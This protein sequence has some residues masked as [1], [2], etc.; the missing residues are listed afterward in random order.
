MENIELTEQ[1]LDVKLRD[2]AFAKLEPIIA[3]IWESEK[4]VA[5]P[6]VVRGPEGYVTGVAYKPD[7]IAQMRIMDMSAAARVDVS[8]EACHKALETLIIKKHTDPR[9]LNYEDDP[10]YWKGA[11]YSLGQFCMMRVPEVK[12]N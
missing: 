9:I 10:T 2:E 1:E 3:Q 6:I 4:R 11:A 12:K 5:F 8:L 7:L